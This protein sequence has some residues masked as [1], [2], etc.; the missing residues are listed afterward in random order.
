MT[1]E[2]HFSIISPMATQDRDRLRY[3]HQKSHNL[4]Q[5]VFFS[6]AVLG[7]PIGIISKFA[8]NSIHPQSR[9]TFALFDKDRDGEISSEELAKVDFASI[10]CNFVRLS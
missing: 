8:S 5:I 7:I 2:R 10:F 1:R 4:A 9:D 6:S 3:Y